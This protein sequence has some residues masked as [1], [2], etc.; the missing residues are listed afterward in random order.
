M[1]HPLSRISSLSISSRHTSSHIS[2][3]TSSLINSPTGKQYQQPYYQ[4]PY[5]QNGV[6]PALESKA[7]QAMVFGIIGL[8]FAGII[9]G[10]IAITT[11][12]SCKRAGY[13]GGKATAGFVLG[14]IDIVLLAVV[15][16][17]YIA[18]LYR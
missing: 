5:Y 16:L 7:T 8:F 17:V 15:W 13:T 12:N 14:I 11:A 4:Q 3:P 9:F 2:N 18:V 1:S 10:I 6:D